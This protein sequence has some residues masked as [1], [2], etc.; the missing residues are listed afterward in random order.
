[1]THNWR[2]SISSSWYCIDSVMA[3][4]SSV[5]EAHG[6][7]TKRNHLTLK[8]LHQ[9]SSSVIWSTPSFNFSHISLAQQS[10]SVNSPTQSWM[11]W[12]HCS[13]W[14]S[15]ELP[16]I[17]GTDIKRHMTLLIWHPKDWWVRNIN[18]NQLTSTFNCPEKISTWAINYLNRKFS[19]LGWLSYGLLDAANCRPLSGRLGACL[20]PLCQAWK[21]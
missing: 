9:V 6:T 2:F 20:H 14:E 12:E 1:M 10:I 13:G 5:W 4:I 21:Q 11:L 15:L 16:S 8:L 3:A 18:F 7:S 17:I 19:I